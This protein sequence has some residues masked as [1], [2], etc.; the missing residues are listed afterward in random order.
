MASRGW[1]GVLAA[2]LL[3]TGLAAAGAQSLAE[4][5]ARFDRESDDVQKAKLLNKLGDAQLEEVR[6]ATARDDYSAVGL[7]MEKYRDNVKAAL[8]ALKRRHP[9]GERHASG[10]KQL[11]IHVRK[12]LRDL[13]EILRLAPE[14]YQPPLQLVAKDL[15][16]YDD[17][18]LIKLF[19]RRPGNQ[20]PPA[21]KNTESK[22]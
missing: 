13:N 8:E 7:T 9:D 12:A 1:I 20:P 16:A 15:T 17:E 5:Q 21:P 4:L 10:Y 18:L 6:K 11:Q 3:V 22:P 14:A 19:P 2:V